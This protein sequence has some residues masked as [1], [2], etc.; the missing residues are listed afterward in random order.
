MGSKL[1]KIPLIVLQI[2]Y[3]TLKTMEDGTKNSEKYPKTVTKTVET[4]CRKIYHKNKPE[5]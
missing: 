1:Q 3:E 5:A 2:H 4:G